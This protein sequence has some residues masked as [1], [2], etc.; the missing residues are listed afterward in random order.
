ML[1]S[2]KSLGTK[3]VMR[4]ITA[5]DHHAEGM[6]NSF[7]QKIGGQKLSPTSSENTNHHHHLVA[8]LYSTSGSPLVNL[9][10]FFYHE[11]FL[12]N[13][14]FGLIDHDL[15]P[16]FWVL[17]SSPAPVSPSSPSF[18]PIVMTT[19]KSS[20]ETIGWLLNPALHCV[21]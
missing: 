11:Y 3:L 14:F 19:R 8:G 4:D 10:Q 6:D 13:E 17:L 1:N 16:V 2:S 18:P 21:T 9:S 7:Q 5:S 15:M 12:K 20:A